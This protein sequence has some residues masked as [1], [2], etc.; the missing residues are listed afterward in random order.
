MGPFQI[1]FYVR[2]D[3]FRVLPRVAKCW[4][5]SGFLA[6][7]FIEMKG[8]PDFKQSYF[9]FHMIWQPLKFLFELHKAKH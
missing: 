4:Q 2:R 8:F 1:G 3:T 6:I 5:F 9:V 7:T